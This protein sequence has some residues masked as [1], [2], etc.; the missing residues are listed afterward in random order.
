MKSSA[1]LLI[2]L[3]I[4]TLSP[5]AIKAED[6]NNSNAGQDSAVA[7]ELTKFDVND[8]TLE[9]AWKIVNNTDHDV[10][11]CSSLTPESTFFYDVYLDTDT[12][13]LILRRQFNLLLEEGKYISKPFINRYARLCSGQEKN[14]S[15]S[16]VLPIVQCA[17]FN[18]LCNE[19]QY[20]D[21]N[22]SC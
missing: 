19:T 4:C 2:F 11:I 9:L 16:L 12:K 8:T 15:I 22:N 18:N 21:N 17:A 6:A 5:Q 10:W 20:S 3:I 13:T 1:R 7:I 14:E